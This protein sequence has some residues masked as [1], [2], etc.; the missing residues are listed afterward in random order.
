[1]KNQNAITKQESLPGFLN[2]YK[3]PIKSGVGLL[4]IVL[5]LVEIVRKVKGTSELARGMKVIAGENSKCS[6]KR[7][8]QKRWPLYCVSE[9]AIKPAAGQQLDKPRTI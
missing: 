7:E 5:I 1:M 2:Q 4:L 6:V 9:V 3:T 8:W